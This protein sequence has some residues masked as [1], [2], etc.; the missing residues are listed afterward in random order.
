MARILVGNGLINPD[1]IIEIEEKT[2]SLVVEKGWL[3]DT[4]AK[5]KVIILKVI[6]K[7]GLYDFY[8]IYNDKRIISILK[9]DK[10]STLEVGNFYCYP[11]MLQYDHYE[12]SNMLYDESINSRRDFMEKY[13]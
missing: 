9:K 11:G 4:T 8:T 12:E 2:V 6:N 7:K 1:D 13:L 10:K 5:F 3:S